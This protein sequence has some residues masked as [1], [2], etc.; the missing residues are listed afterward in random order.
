MTNRP[1]R[2]FDHAKD[3]EAVQRIWIETGWI[4]DDKDERQWVS[5]F[6]S[7]GEAEVA[8]IDQEAECAVHWTRG[9][10][11]YQEET[12]TM[13]AVTA[14]TTSHIARR[15][16]FAKE[17]T[18]R[19]IAR[20]YEAGMDVSSLGIFDQGFYNK[21]GY[22]NGPYETFVQI[23]PSK[24]MINVPYRVPR[25]LTTEQYR[26]IYQALANRKKY[27][28]G[29]VLFP[30]ENIK[31]ELEMTEKPFGLGYYDGPNGSLSHFI[32]GTMKGEHGPFR[33]LMR[34]YQT[35]DQ[36]MEL[37]GL[38]KSLGDQ[39]NSFK[40]LEF[41]EFQLQDLLDQPFRTDRGAGGDH[42]QRIEAVSYWQLRIVN[43]E[44]CLANTH[45]YGPVVQFNL[46]LTDPL[47]EILPPDAPWQGLAGNYVI[48][49]GK[50]SSA[51]PGTRDGLPNMKASINAFSR[52]WLGVRPA[53]NIAISDDLTADQELIEALD[54]TLRLP[55]PHF[56][57]DF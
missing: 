46:E 36:L 26:D 40:T 44:N 23:D 51:V 7:I 21:V 17:L 48:T 49:F 13:G 30:E 35:N 24:L 10:M 55:R 22:G 19:S 29:V 37:L 15:Q 41:G 31:V 27:H 34:A 56:G 9:T 57:W 33:I 5:D 50:E 4:D 32:W 1:F 54:R 52:M 43:L 11:Q 12:L 14:V 42:P 8:T 25:R 6:F 18:A 3:I 16:G 39:V 2:K 20:Q 45:L 38:M 47:N 53:S 28:G